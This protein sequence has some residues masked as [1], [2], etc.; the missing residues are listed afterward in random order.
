MPWRPQQVRLLIQQKEAVTKT[1][2]GKGA[3]PGWEACEIQP[4]LQ[5]GMHWCSKKSTSAYNR[6]WFSYMPLLCGRASWAGAQE[7]Q[8][9]N[10]V[11]RSATGMVQ[12]KAYSESCAVDNSSC[13]PSWFLGNPYAGRLNP[14]GLGAIFEDWKN[15]KSVEERIEGN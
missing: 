8:K 5:L 9:G 1:L 7:K 13:G 4:S 12:Q 15:G 14:A 3:L 11:S 6:G 10:T 2:K